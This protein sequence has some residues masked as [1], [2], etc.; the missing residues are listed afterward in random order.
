MVMIR[1]RIAGEVSDQ[2]SEGSTARTLSR[3]LLEALLGQLV[4][5]LHDL[6]LALHA[7]PLGEALAQPLLLDV[8]VL[9]DALLLLLQSLRV[10]LELRQDA[11]VHGQLRRVDLASR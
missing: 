10:G 4:A 2:D 9:P 7:V 3:D 6:G 1:T 11:G 5:Q 8:L